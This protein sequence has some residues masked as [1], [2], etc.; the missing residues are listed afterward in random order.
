MVFYLKVWDKREHK[1]ECCGKNLEHKPKTY[2]FDHILEKGNKKYAHLRHVEEN[3]CLLCFDCHTNKALHPQLVKLR[4]DT[5]KKL[6]DTPLEIQ[7]QEN[8]PN[9]LSILLWL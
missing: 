6:C 5:I 1:C 4:H 9:N 2:N 7:K 8:L 3:I